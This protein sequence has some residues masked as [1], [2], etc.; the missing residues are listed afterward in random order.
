MGRGICV[1]VAAV[2][3][4][5]PLPAETPKKAAPQAQGA[6][7]SGGQARLPAELARK[8]DEAKQL[9]APNLSPAAAEKLGRIPSRELMIRSLSANPRTKLILDKPLITPKVGRTQLPDAEAAL[10]ALDWRNGIRFMPTSI[11]RYYTQ[12]SL[13]YFQM[14][15]SFFFSYPNSPG[16][17]GTWTFGSR[18][19]SRTMESFFPFTM[20]LDVPSTP[21][22]YLITLHLL[23]DDGRC[24]AEWITP[25]QDG[26]SVI[27]LRVNTTMWCLTPLTDGS[28]YVCIVSP[29]S[30][31]VYRPDFTGLR[32]G[33]MVIYCLIF[34]N[35]APPNKPW[36]R[37]VV[38]NGITVARL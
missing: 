26:L 3:F 37:I 13:G 38:F 36:N 22:T 32:K 2:L 7:V 30:W 12:L 16:S 11:P 4:A 9:R 31:A 6:S 23:T 25:R 34:P 15:D 10:E 29:T 18:S 5:G 27:M 33:N 17:P 19:S 1:L 21:A 20:Y 8:L 14:S 28:G 35:I 24:P